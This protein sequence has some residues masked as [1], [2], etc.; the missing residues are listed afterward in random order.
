MSRAGESFFKWEFDNR[1][2]MGG[3]ERTVFMDEK[4]GV[5]KVITS[6]YS[7]RTGEVYPIRH[8]AKYTAI[9]LE[10]KN[11]RELYDF[12]YPENL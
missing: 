5:Y 2:R 1:N 8:T 12:L 6:H 3:V 9:H 11:E 4:H 7:E 10:F